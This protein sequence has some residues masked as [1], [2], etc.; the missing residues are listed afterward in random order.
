V[1]VLRGAVS[2]CVA[3]RHSVLPSGRVVPLAAFF[4]TAP[5]VREALRGIVADAGPH[6]DRELAARLGEL[7]F[8]VARRTVVKYRAQL[9]IPATR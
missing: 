6:T 2:R 3:G 7:G 8:R 5:G 4:P 1:P 9:G